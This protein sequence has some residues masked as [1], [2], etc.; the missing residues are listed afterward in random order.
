M[1]P[2]ADDDDD[3]SE[4]LR[5]AMIDV[6]TFDCV[7]GVVAN[8][9]LASTLAARRKRSDDGARKNLPPLLD[10]DDVDGVRDVTAGSSGGW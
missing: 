5:C 3:E 10:A 4:A 9:S 8:N 1:T 6:T 2:A 7:C